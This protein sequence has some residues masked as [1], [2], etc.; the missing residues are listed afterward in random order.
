LTA[1][2]KTLAPISAAATRPAGTIATRTAA[3][4]AATVA[5]K[6]GTLAGKL[7]T[8]RRTAART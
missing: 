7:P 4:F 3:K 6:R 1:T 5:G 2:A 8:R